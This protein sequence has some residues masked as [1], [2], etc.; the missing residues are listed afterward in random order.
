MLILLLAHQ[1]RVLDG[2]REGGHIG[3]KQYAAHWPVA[4]RRRDGGRSVTSGRAGSRAELVAAAAFERAAGGVQLSSSQ[5]S[6]GALCGRLLADRVRTTGL[7]E[8]SA[9]GVRRG[10]RIAYRGR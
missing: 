10:G 3:R 7:F 1:Q 4:G 8:A 5:C 9:E 6:G 2:M